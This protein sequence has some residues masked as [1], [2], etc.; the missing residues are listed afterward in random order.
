MNIV[1]MLIIIILLLRLLNSGNDEGIQIPKFIYKN[2]EIIFYGIF[3]FLATF[4]IS[5]LSTLNKMFE[6]EKVQKGIQNKM[7][8]TFSWNFISGVMNIADFISDNFLIINFG[9][10]CFIFLVI[11]VK[12]FIKE[13]DEDEEEKE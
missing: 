8:E 7:T 12:S 6:Y 5:F 13:E 9:V 4:A 3:I 11:F 2:I 10:F 1:L